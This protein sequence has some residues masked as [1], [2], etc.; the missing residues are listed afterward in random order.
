MRKCEN[1][2]MK[3]FLFFTLLL[4]IVT[5]GAWGGRLRPDGRSED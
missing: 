4:T 1:M 2:K 3:R 5:Q